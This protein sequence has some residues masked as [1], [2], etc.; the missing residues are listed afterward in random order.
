MAP[1]KKPPRF[2]MAVLSWRPA[3]VFTCKPAAV[4]IPARVSG[5]CE[6]ALRCA[7]LSEAKELDRAETLH[8]VQG[9]CKQSSRIPLPG[10]AIQN[11][12]LRAAA[13]RE[14]DSSKH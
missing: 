2:S 6:A 8:F 3:I 1:Y 12:I 5:A 7:V 9:D 10:R 13:K 11:G 4:V 14:N